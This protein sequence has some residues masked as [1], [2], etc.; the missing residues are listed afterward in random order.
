MGISVRFQIWR[1][2]KMRWKEVIEGQEPEG[3]VFVCRTEEQ[4]YYPV[5]AIFSN[6]H[7]NAPGKK[8]WRIP[9]DGAKIG[10]VT[11]WMPIPK[12]PRKD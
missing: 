7:P 6:Y 8:L 10:N 5:I 1:E 4:G 2:F 3:K 11:H 12:A 9:F